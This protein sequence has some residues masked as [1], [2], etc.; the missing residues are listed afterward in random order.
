MKGGF[1]NPPTTQL[2]DF[3]MLDLS[4]QRFNEGGG[5]NNPPNPGGTAGGP[6][7]PA[8]WLQ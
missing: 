8:R 6:Y 7:T 3:T 1:N 4:D 5:F 2:K